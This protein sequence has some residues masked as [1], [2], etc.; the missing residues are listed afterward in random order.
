MSLRQ[1]VFVCG[2]LCSGKSTYCEMRTKMPGPPAVIVHVSHLVKEIA[3]AQTRQD[4][5]STANL[6]EAIASSLMASI[7]VSLQCWNTVFVDGIRQIQILDSIIPKLRV[8][9]CK[10]EFVWMSV[11]VNTQKVRYD[12]MA[13]QN[14]TKFNQSFEEAVAGDW[15]LGMRDLSKLAERVGHYEGQK[16]WPGI[17]LRLIH[18]QERFVSCS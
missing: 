11:D 16:I 6:H 9:N 17:D 15:D 8:L 12:Y 13:K 1:V 5:Q 18:I 2:Q 7:E 3:G 10:M 4:L 14:P